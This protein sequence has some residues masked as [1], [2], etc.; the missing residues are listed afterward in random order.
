MV[1][2][3]ARDGGHQASQEGP[4]NYEGGGSGGEGAQGEGLRPPRPCGKS[5]QGEGAQRDRRGAP[6]LMPGPKRHKK[7]EGI[8]TSSEASVS[9]SSARRGRPWASE[10]EEQEAG[11]PSPTLN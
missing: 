3:R 4:G 1:P 7:R 6:G 10:G 11:D 8:Q 5:G 2:G 9:L